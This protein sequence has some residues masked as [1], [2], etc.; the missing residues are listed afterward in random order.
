MMMRDD[1]PPEELQDSSV[2]RGTEQVAERGLNVSGR[3]ARPQE[4]RRISGGGWD[5]GWGTVTKLL[6]ENGALG[7]HTNP[8]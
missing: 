6:S 8:D 2:G 7:T 5:G 3:Q 4:K 1:P